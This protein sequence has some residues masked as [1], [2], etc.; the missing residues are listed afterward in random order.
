MTAS[1]HIHHFFVS[2]S[3]Y[4]TQHSL[5]SLDIV[6]YFIIIFIIMI[7]RY[8]LLLPILKP[9][10]AADRIVYAIRMNHELL[11]M[12]RFCSLGALFRAILPV[13]LFDEA[14]S[15]IGTRFAVSPSVF[16]DF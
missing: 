1:H 3:I 12:P 14:G 6:F 15:M 13:S 5:L 2:S 10:Y 11:Q 9:T 16:D 7:N 4:F 8:P